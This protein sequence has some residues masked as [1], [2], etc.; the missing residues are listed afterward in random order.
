MA[1]GLQRYTEHFPPTPPP[2]QPSEQSGR[3]GDGA[4]IPVLI[5]S[6]RADEQLTLS[7]HGLERYT[8][9]NGR[10]Q[11]AF[12]HRRVHCIM[13]RSTSP[14]TFQHCSSFGTPPKHGSPLEALLMHALVV[15]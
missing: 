15:Y 8:V 11:T 7:V 10:L 14:V 4:R 5:L 13:I 1:I 2:V 3:P 9:T 6:V 12:Y